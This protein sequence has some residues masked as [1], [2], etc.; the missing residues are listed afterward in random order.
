MS[1]ASSEK[2]KSSR[3]SNWSEADS[4]LLVQAVAYVQD[5][6]ICMNYNL[7]L[8]DCSWWSKSS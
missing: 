4:L 2:G 3:T 8:S 5:N 1:S 6:G 7:V